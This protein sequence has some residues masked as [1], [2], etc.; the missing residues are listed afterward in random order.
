MPSQHFWTLAA[1]VCGHRGI[2]IL[3]AAPAW[4]CLERD[5][6]TPSTRATT[7]YSPLAL[8]PPSISELALA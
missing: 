3:P 5:M 1:S 4:L 7:S 6:A 8:G 2:I